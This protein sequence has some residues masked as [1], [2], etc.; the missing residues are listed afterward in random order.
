MTDIALLL[1]MLDQA[2]DRRSWHGTNLRGSL[3]G[4]DATRAAWRPAVGRHNIWEIA[5]HAA[6]WKYVVRRRF[7]G[8]GR[9]SFPLAGSNWFGRRAG[10]ER[11]WKRD[12]RL[13]DDTH[14][15][16]R[17]T[18]AA[19]GPAALQRTPRGSTVSNLQ[20][21]TGIIAHD[22]HHAGQVQLLKRLYDG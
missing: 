17:A 5:V 2:Y 3:R 6:Y 22:L 7:T 11:E 8:E 19:L 4:V 15:R 9:G 12:L 13:L 10:G 21:I 20:M 1:T 14:R 16:L 18:I